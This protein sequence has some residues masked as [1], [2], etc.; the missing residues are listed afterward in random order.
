MKRIRL[1]DDLLRALCREPA[2]SQACGLSFRR[3]ARA[4]GLAGRAILYTVKGELRA[5]VGLTLGIAVHSQ[6]HPERLAT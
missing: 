6:A 5:R 3:T 1:S 2:R 4:R